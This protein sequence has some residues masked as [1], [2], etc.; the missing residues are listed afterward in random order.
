LAAK[1]AEFAPDSFAALCW[2]RAI[3]QL[4]TLR[5]YAAA[6]NTLYNASV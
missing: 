4:Q 1:L 3:G 6:Q 2:A 5:F